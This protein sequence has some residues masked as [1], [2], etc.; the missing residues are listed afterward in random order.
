MYLILFNGISLII[1][2]KNVYSYVLS[3]I[4]LFMVG[5]SNVNAGGLVD[6]PR[7]GDF[8]DYIDSIINFI[9]SYVMPL[10]LAIAFI[11]LVWGIIQYF[12]IG[13]AN[14]EAKVKGKSLIIYAIVGFVIILSFYGI[15]NILV[16]G[17]GLGGGD[18]SGNN[19]PQVPSTI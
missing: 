8:G 15:V 6:D 3:A 18:L 2:M 13:G 7:A 14:D 10:I 12:V 1:L 19:I 16:G 9:N 4:T 17:I 5:F 11:F